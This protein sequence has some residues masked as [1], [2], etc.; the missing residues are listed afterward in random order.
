MNKNI[1]RMTFL[2]MINL[3]TM[4]SIIL[5]ILIHLLAWIICVCVC[6]GSYCFR[7][8]HHGWHKFMNSSN[9]YVF[10]FINSGNNLKKMRSKTKRSVYQDECNCNVFLARLTPS[11]LFKQY[12]NCQST[13]PVSGYPTIE[14][15]PTSVSLFSTGN[16]SALFNGK[17]NGFHNLVGDITSY[18]Q[19]DRGC[20]AFEKYTLK[21]VKNAPMVAEMVQLKLKHSSTRRSSVLCDVYKLNSTSLTGSFT[22]SRL[23]KYFEYGSFAAKSAILPILKEYTLFQ[24]SKGS[25]TNRMV[26]R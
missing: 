5:Y 2:D 25:F 18:E 16:A 26:P 3:F 1:N 15:V 9:L 23:S 21:Y 4:C 22:I 19:Y 7:W 24:N 17:M 6:I 13:A 11:A 10:V 14:K 8:Y 12:W 20:N